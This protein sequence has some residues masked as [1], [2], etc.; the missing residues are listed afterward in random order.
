MSD[1]DPRTP[2]AEQPVAEER[3]A[4]DEQPVA[5]ETPRLP[6]RAVWPYLRPY[7]RRAASSPRLVALATA[8]TAL[9]QPLLV[10]A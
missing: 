8:A 1:E 5:E 10:R 9:A 3:P 4:S 2:T 7:R 6:L